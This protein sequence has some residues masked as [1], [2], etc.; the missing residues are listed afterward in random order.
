[1]AAHRAGLGALLST[2]DGGDI[3]GFDVDQSGSDAVL[4]SSGS[5]E[6]FDQKS[7]KVLTTY[8]PPYGRKNSY[9]RR[10]LLR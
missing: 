5:I 2:K 7:G 10:H 6:I 1:M 9:H 4:S 3:D 8:T